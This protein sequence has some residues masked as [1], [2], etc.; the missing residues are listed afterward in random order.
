MERQLEQYQSKEFLGVEGLVKAASDIIRQ[1]NES[2]S[3]EAGVE[4]LVEIP[5]IRMVR[6]YIT[7]G[8]LPAATGKLH[9]SSL[10][11]YQHLISLLLIKW[12]QLHDFPN[13]MIK[14]ALGN[15]TIKQ[16]EKAFGDRVQV[17]FNQ[18]QMDSF[19]EKYG[20]E[21]DEGLVV[22]HDPRARAEYLANLAPVRSQGTGDMWSHNLVA[23]GLELNI[24]QSFRAPDTEEGLRDLIKK[25]E[26]LVTERKY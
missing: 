22:L 12:L 3:G 20:R 13:S 4:K 16:M 26:T 21:E 23:D 5:N 24:R 8:L 19:V 9:Q 6:Y 11:G 10:F 14:E 15:M 7:E 1:F 17:F 25:L 18:S 2:R